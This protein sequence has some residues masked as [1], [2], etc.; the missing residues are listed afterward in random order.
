MNSA[1]RIRAF[2][3]ARLFAAAGDPA[4]VIDYVSALVAPDRQTV[5]LREAD[6]ETVLQMLDMMAALLSAAVQRTDSDP[7]PARDFIQWA[8]D[9]S[10]HTG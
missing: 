3:T 4:P 10:S 7:M 6:L 8:H 5:E 9:R 2:L 1:E